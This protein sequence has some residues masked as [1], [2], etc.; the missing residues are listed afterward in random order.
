MPRMR[1]LN[2]A[3][4]AH[5]DSPPV[6]SSVERK[7]F[8]DFS[9]SVLDA[10][11]GLRSP[12][13]RI[14]FLLA[15]GYF[16]AT[17]RFFPAERYH[18]RDIAFVARVA[19][20]APDAFSAEGYR[21]RTRLHH[22]GRI[23]D[24]QGFRPFDDQ[25][26]GRLVTEIGKMARVHLKPRL[27][28]WR[29]TDFLVE[30]RIQLPCARRLTDLI[31]V[32]LNERRRE[33]ASVVDANLSTEL[34][35]ML[36]S[37]FLQGEGESRYRLTLLKTIS[38]STSPGRIRKTVADLEV[39]ADLYERITPLLEILDIGTEGV[40]YYAGGVQRSEMFQLQR[41]SDAD[42]HLHA[43]AF[44]ADQH[45][46]L[47]D[48]TIDILLS[49]MQ[50]FR[51]TVD[52]EHR[53]EVFA[54]RK[55]AG[56]RL[57]E[58]LDAVDTE[59]LGLREAIRAL[60][61]DETMPDARKLDGIRAVLNRDRESAVDILREDIRKSAADDEGVFQD[62]LEHRSVRLQNRISPIL[63]RVEFV[64]DASMTDLMAALACFRERDGSIGPGMPLAFLTAA[65]RD[66]VSNGPKGFRVS[67][68]K[69]FLF[70]HVAA[71]IKAGSLNLE[72]SYK[73]RPL[74]D[75]LI[76]RV[77]WE[78]ER[79]TLLE[80][81]GLAEFT[82]PAPVLK[83]L[84]T[85]LDR[86]YEETNRGAR[87][88]TN[89]YLKFSSPGSFRVATPALD[90]VE[91][92]PLRDVMPRRHLVPLSEILA[93]HRRPALRHARGIQALAADQRRPDALARDHDR[94]HNG[95]RL[96]HRRPEDGSDL[97]RHSGTRTGARGQLALLSRQRR[98]RQ[99]SCRG[100]H[101]THGT[102]T[103]P[104]SLARGPPHVKRRPEV[105]GSEA[106]AQCQPF[107]QV[108]RPDAGRQRLHL[109]R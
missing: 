24:L 53:D 78:R 33:L 17:R 61:D 62:I 25:A 10:A 98:R 92:E 30:K 85:A 38:Q 1:I 93:G 13:S 27:V 4:Q 80:R 2:A 105:R 103:D 28:F 51:T 76:G 90:E 7:R 87:D 31:R 82:D 41:R 5:Y 46:R 42:R 81:A 3:E 67:L 49:V 74:D 52:R 109:H 8:F 99:R 35:A 6:F 37:L 34:R 59:V 39:L 36:D 15:Y 97:P 55:A 54:Q 102:A 48:A 77:R 88:G 79:R 44:I 43:I 19:G 72:G 21:Q 86:Q 56:A 68:C 14:G 57:G 45:H 63:K 89:P 50:S 84:R 9:R 18:E 91:S 94:R 64:G 66:A 40:R 32:R 104:P 69:V 83:E 23:L 20:D 47:Q 96:R 95:A 12:A 107:V 70:Q 65:E 71:A 60:L 75:Y 100:R 11:H 101:G 16:R 106:L 108:L 26:E 29:C 58:M 73:Y 22:Q